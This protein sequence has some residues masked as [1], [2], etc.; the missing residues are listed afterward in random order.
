MPKYVVSSSLG[1][2]SWNNTA[3]LRGDLTEEV[4][5]VASRHDGDVLVAGSGTLARGLLAAGLVD[6]VRLMVFPVVL[7]S[8]RRLFDESTAAT[9]LRLLE[10]RTLG[11]DGVALLRY[12]PVGAG[13]GSRP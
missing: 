13:I 9:T 10:H 12:A 6:E 5:K 4:G 11:E 2:A 1:E 8:G 3:V 7:G